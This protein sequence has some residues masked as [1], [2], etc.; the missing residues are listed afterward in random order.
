MAWKL[1]GAQ[2]THRPVRVSN[3]FFG[4]D[5]LSASHYFEIVSTYGFSQL[6][7]P[8]LLIRPSEP[9]VF[10]DAKPL[11]ETPVIEEQSS[12]GIFDIAQ[13]WAGV[14]E[15]AEEFLARPKAGAG[16]FFLG[17]GLFQSSALNH[18]LQPEAYLSSKYLE[19]FDLIFAKN[20][21]GHIDHAESPHRLII[22]VIQAHSSKEADWRIV[23]H[24]GVIGKQRI[25]ESVLHHEEPSLPDRVSAKGHLARS[26]A[27]LQHIRRT[28]PLVPLVEQRHQT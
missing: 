19:S 6:S 1:K 2:G 11:R 10:A 22:R 23:G 5:H 17:Q 12:C 26:F 13:K 20:T 21:R 15:G 9:R 25:S 3:V 4:L 28:I 16:S 27:D 14:H 8:E 24:Q 18:R 7:G